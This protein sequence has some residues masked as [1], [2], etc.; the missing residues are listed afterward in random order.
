MG[1]AQNA[2][3][4]V[5]QPNGS[6]RQVSDGNPNGTV[7]GQGP[8]DL[9]S[10]FGATPVPQPA[11][12]GATR[13]MVGNTTVYTSTQSPSAVTANT[14]AEA[15]LTVTGVAATDLVLVSKPTAQG[16]LV[17]GTARAS[18]TNTVGL[19]LGNVTGST[20]TPTASES[21]VLTT[22]PAA[23]QIS[24]TLTPAVVA[25]N[26][27]V[28]QQFAVTGVSAGMFVAVNKPTFQTG[29]MITNARAVANGIL[30]I[31]FLNAT[32]SPITPTAAE[33]YKIFAAYGLSVAPVMSEKNVVIAPGSVAA[34]T[35]AEQTFTVPGLAAGTF[36]N[37]DKPSSTPGITIGG[38][39]VSA[40]NTLAITFVNNTPAA[41]VPPSETYAVSYFP[42][43][44]PAAG[45]STASASTPSTATD[46]ALVSLGLIAP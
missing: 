37:V 3:L 7:L 2:V 23:L 43:A 46:A 26:A 15:S 32:A 31:T 20:I 9:I 41:I 14:T 12:R 36:V 45:S 8:S 17:V 1:L 18:A 5:N 16:G 42:T 44:N 30:G 38:A 13:G 33:V 34:N 24:A 6:P 21:Y 29:L 40:A 28:E 4:P 22:I 27:I 39:R 35:S 10:F 11:T 25:A 19:S